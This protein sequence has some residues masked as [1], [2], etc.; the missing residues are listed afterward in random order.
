[1]QNKTTVRVYHQELRIVGG[2]NDIYVHRCANLVNDLMEDTMKG[3]RISLSDGAIL[4][5][6]NLADQYFQEK[7]LADDLRGQL[8]EALDECTRLSKELGECK[9]ELRRLETE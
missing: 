7:K 4:A 3:P 5:A 9:R 6:M 1:M 8:K 2:E